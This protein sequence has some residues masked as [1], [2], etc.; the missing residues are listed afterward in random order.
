MP[1][2]FVS[3]KALAAGSLL[4]N[5]PRLPT[6]QEN[7]HEHFRSELIKAIWRFCRSEEH[8]S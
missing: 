4:V 3:G 1:L 2:F 6:K 7:T 8:Q 5:Y